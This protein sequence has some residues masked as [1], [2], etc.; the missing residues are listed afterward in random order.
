MW[1]ETTASE[2]WG[3]PIIDLGTFALSRFAIIYILNSR[4]WASASQ[5]WQITVGRIADAHFDFARATTL[6][7]H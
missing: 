7:K 1:V 3:I 4:F 6:D 5:P 2:I